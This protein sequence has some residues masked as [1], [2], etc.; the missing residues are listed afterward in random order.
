[1]GRFK[2]DKEEKK[3]AMY[4][5]FKPKIYEFIGKNECKNI[6]ENAVIKEYEKRIKNNRKK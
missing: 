6:A 3:E 5:S 4:V 2:L 1:M